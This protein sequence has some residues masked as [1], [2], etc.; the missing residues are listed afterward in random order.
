VVADDCRL[1]LR[2]QVRGRH[3]GQRCLLSRGAAERDRY[4]AAGGLRRLHLREDGRAVGEG[5]VADRAGALPADAAWRGQH[6]GQREIVDAG[7]GG[8]GGEVRVLRHRHVDIRGELAGL[9]AAAGGRGR[10][11]CWRGVHRD[12]RRLG[13]GNRGIGR[14]PRERGGRLGG[15]GWHP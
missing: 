5:I 1:I 15:R 4:V 2:L 3:R 7:G 13:G 6:E 14:R 8:N 9:V 11:G 10:R 12:R